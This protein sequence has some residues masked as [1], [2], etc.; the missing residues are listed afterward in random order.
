MKPR[1]ILSV[2]RLSFPLATALAAL[3]NLAAPSAFAANQNWTGGGANANWSTALNWN[4]A[5]PGATSGTTNTDVATFNA[6]IA[7]TWGLTGS[8]ILIDSAAQNIGGLSFTTAAD[9]YFVG[10]TAGNSLKL[11]SA[12]TIQILAG[13]TTTNAVE[14]VNAPLVIQLANGTYTFANNSA[15]GTGA[16]A[17]T[18]NFAGGITGGA[19]GATVLTLSGSNTN[20]N[21]ISGVIGNGT[22]T[23]LAITKSGAGTWVLG[24]A[25][26][27]TGSTVL[28]G[29][30]LKYTANNTGIKALNFGVLTSSGTGTNMS[31]ARPPAPLMPKQP[32]VT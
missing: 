32:R 17:G 28:N 11:T 27:Y 25:N 3:F 15:N 6:A 14:T 31:A 12:G 24:N 7:N 1:R 20:A 29:G 19:A 10:T 18:L 30:T 21:T 22:A 13:L 2:A 26:T 5:A 16:G 8:P 4:G 23:T 9:N